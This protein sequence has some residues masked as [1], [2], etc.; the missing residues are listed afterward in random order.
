MWGNAHYSPE[1]V[2]GGF[3]GAGSWQ[4]VKTYDSIIDDPVTRLC[5]A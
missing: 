5:A 3:V 4:K 1:N 2:T